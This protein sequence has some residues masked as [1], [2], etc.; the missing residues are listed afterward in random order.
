[1]KI[2][3]HFITHHFWG[4]P[5]CC[6]QFRLDPPHCRLAAER[7]TVAGRLYEFIGDPS[8]P[9]IDPAI[10][11]LATVAAPWDSSHSGTN[12]SLSYCLKN[13]TLDPFK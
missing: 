13:C 5:Y 8:A 10:A 4:V 7:M 12:R 6:S 2:L 9:G 11:G 1:M 3:I